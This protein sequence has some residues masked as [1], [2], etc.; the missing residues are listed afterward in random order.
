MTWAWSLGNTGDVCGR[1]RRV[2]TGLRD[3]AFAEEREDG[4]GVRRVIHRAPEAAPGLGVT[5]LRDEGLR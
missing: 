5:S 4:D 3:R 1:R 2:V